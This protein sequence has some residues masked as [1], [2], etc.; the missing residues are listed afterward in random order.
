MKKNSHLTRVAMMAALASVASIGCFTRG[1]PS[2][3]AVVPAAAPESGMT[4]VSAQGTAPDAPQAGTSAVSSAAEADE[5]LAALWQE[6]TR[7]GEALDVCLGPG[8]GLD[9]TVFHW[10]EMSGLPVRVSAGGTI[11]LPVIGTVGA[12]GRSPQQLEQD[13]AAK[14]RD[15]VMRDPSVRVTVTDAASQQVAITGAVARPGLIPLR[16]DKR[17]VSDL[18]AEAG[19]LAQ[20]AGGRVLFYPASG[21][22]CSA[23]PRAVAS[24]A[25][26]AGVTPIEIDTNVADKSAGRNDPLL[27]PVIGGDAIVV[28]RGRYFVDGWVQTP[29]AY[30]ISPG[31]TAFGALSAAG[32]AL[33]PADLASVVVWRGQRDGSKKRIDV[34]LEKISVGQQ[35]DVT[36]QSGDVVSVP[37]SAALMVPYSG[38][39]FLTN[40]VRVGAGVSMTGF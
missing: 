34:D 38:Y 37:A 16:R 40:V 30:E 31:T 10:P 8:D 17:T 13:I 21:N 39:W 2:K 25:P 11:T 24:L 33:Y 12:A 4:T 29:G 22:G 9:V 1:L 28:N 36:L 26:P 5:R 19:A 32:G 15:G 35:N 6:R 20:H 18:I 7:G 27:L 23:G 3:S 14:L